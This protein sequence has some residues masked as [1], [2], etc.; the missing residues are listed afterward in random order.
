MLEEF[1]SNLDV[2][3]V[4]SYTGQ[5]FDEFMDAVDNKVDEY[6][7]FYKAE[8]ERILKKK[9]EDEKKRQTKSL[10]KLMKDMDMK[11]RKKPGQDGEVLSDFDDD[12]EV[13]EELQGEVLPDEEEEARELAELGNPSRE[14][15]FA[16]DRQSELDPT[17]DADL[18]ARYQQA[19][20]ARGKPVS[21][22]T[23][24]NIARYINRT[25]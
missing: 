23:A 14:Y 4:S 20:E 8:R 3:G 15:T 13:D 19:M 5:G 24:E 16:E 2:V 21:S 1:Y 9:E 12:D 17:K 18:Q 10:N 22:Q 6:N 7:E 11:D 25:Q